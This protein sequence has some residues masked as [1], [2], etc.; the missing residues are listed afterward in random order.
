MAQRLILTAANIIT[1]T[2]EG[3]RAQALVIEDGSLSVVYPREGAIETSIAPPLTDNRMTLGPRELDD[4]MAKLEDVESPA[5]H[6]GLRWQPRF[7]PGNRRSIS[8]RVAAYHFDRLLGIGMVPPTIARRIG[9]RRLRSR[10]ASLSSFVASA[11]R[12]SA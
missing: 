9:G 4:F 1:M 8:A 10:L 12:A 2:A 3:D 11:C 5:V 7:Q 6:A